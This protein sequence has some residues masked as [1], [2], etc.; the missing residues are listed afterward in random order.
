MRSG[1]RILAVAA[2]LFVAIALA[3][4]AVAANA[5]APRSH[6][7]GPASGASRIFKLRAIRPPNGYVLDT[8]YTPRPEHWQH[9]P[10]SVR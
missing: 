9:V 3:G 4:T 1:K 8:S 10:Q 2:G 7:A 5:T 6:Q